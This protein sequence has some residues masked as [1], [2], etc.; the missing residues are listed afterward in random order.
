MEKPYLYSSK[1]GVFISG[2]LLLGHI[3]LEA[4][5]GY[6]IYKPF[7]ETDW[8]LNQGFFWEITNSEGTK[9]LKYIYGKKEDFQKGK[10]AISTRLG[11]RYYLFTNEKAPKNNFYIGANI[12]ANLSQAD[13]T[14]F[15]FGY[16]HSFGFKNKS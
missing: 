13:F 7:Y 1:F 11:L 10:E 2:E 5:L 16:V 3:G 9:E 4:T 12:N 8:K 14:E 15:S 6:N